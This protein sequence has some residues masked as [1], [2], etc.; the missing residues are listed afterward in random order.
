MDNNN[1]TLK[2]P[3]CGMEST[4][5]NFCGGCGTPLQG[6]PYVQPVQQ[7]PIYQQQPVQQQYAPQQQQTWK[8]T[9]SQEGSYMAAV[10]RRPHVILNGNDYGKIKGGDSI[11]ATVN[12]DVI[13]VTIKGGDTFAGSTKRFK[14]TGPNP[15]IT[16]KL[17]A[18]AL[19]IIAAPVFTNITDAYI[20]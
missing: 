17:Q 8:V 9:I 13:D 10:T 4:G 14:I 19:G 1:L 3:N 15:H 2:C 5:L 18:K 7:Q 16:F 12:T 11:Y 6:Q 20:M